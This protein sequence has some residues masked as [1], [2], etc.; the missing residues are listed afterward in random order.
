MNVTLLTKIPWDKVCK[1]GGAVLLGTGSTIKA[2]KTD[3]T[4]Q[5]VI[6]YGASKLV[7]KIGKG[8]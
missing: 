7:K 1:I 8:S 2:F 4:V 5:K 3:E 6:K